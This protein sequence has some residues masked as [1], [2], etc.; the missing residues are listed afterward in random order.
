MNRKD[1]ELIAGA[2]KFYHFGAHAIVLD[3]LAIAL[4][5]EM[6]KTNPKF[7]KDKFLEECGITFESK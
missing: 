4:A 1:Y 5:H 6:G 2:I 7:D 3:H